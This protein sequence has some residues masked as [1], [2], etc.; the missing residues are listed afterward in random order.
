MIRTSPFSVMSIKSALSRDFLQEIE[1]TVWC[2]SSTVVIL[3]STR[4]IKRIRWIYII[5]NK[6]YLIL[7]FYTGNIFITMKI[8]YINILDIYSSYWQYLTIKISLPSVITVKSA[9][10]RDFL[11]ETKLPV[12]CGSS[13]VVIYF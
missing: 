13:T 11:Q 6:I 10:S 7:P 8:E 12:R 3:S 5:Y 2:G 1:L 9:R 4:R